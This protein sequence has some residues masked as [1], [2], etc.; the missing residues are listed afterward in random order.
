MTLTSVVPQQGAQPE[1]PRLGFLVNKPQI[2]AKVSSQLFSPSPLN[3]R[4]TS[5]VTRHLKKASNTKDRAQ[6]EKTSI[7][8]VGK[9]KQNKM[10]KT[11]SFNILREKGKDSASMTQGIF[12]E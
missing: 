6:S 3:L 9:S 4:I 12:R 7:A 10:S 11:L 5:W 8:Y 2:C 1:H